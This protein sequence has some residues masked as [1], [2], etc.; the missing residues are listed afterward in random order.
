MIQPL[1]WC[2]SL[3][4]PFL[5]TSDDE[6]LPIVSSRAY[7]P[8]TK[9]NAYEIA[10]LDKVLD[11]LTKSE[12][13]E[14]KGVREKGAAA[15]SARQDFKVCFRAKREILKTLAAERTSGS[16]KRQRKDLTPLEQL[17]R[18]KVLAQVP[19]DSVTQQQASRMTPPGGHIWNGWKQGA[20]HCHLPPYARFHAPGV[21]MAIIQQLCCV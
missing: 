1:I 4:S 3:C 2:G 20:W 12:K 10:E 17:Q 7:K 21:C 13:Q 19:M 11:T 14:L 18:L 8:G 9:S 15:E 16:R 6:T 5:G